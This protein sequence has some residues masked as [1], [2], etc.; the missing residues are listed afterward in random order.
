MQ[1]VLSM[2]IQSMN[3]EEVLRGGVKEMLFTK[4]IFFPLINGISKL[5]EHVIF[6]KRKKE[7]K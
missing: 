5:S 3:K 4:I 2:Q 7:R 1:L 6:S